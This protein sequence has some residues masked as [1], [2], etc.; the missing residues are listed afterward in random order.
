[1]KFNLFSIERRK[2]ATITVYGEDENE[3]LEIEAVGPRDCGAAM[4]ALRGITDK[5]VIIELHPTGVR[6]CYGS[7]CKRRDLCKATNPEGCLDT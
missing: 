2:I 3:A 7:E 4:R 6:N 5:C 1:M